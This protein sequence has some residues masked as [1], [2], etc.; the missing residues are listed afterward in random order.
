MQ[1]MDRASLEQLLS[2]GLS[3]AEI[4]RRFGLHESTVGYWVEKHGLRAAHRDKHLARGGLACEDL[5]PLVQRG[6]TIAEIAEAVGRSKATVRHWLIRHGL[7]TQGGRGRRPAKE[8]VAAKQAGLSTVVMRCRHH[9]ET[10]F[11]LTGQ[12]SYRCKRC[13]S[14]A[15]ARRRRKVKEI[16]VEEAG[17]CCC[18]CGYS[19]NMRALHFHHLEPSQ[20]RHEINAKGVAIALDKLRVE[21]RKCVLLCS[22]CHAEVED[23][24][25]LI[26]SDM[27]RSPG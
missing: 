8:A 10:E 5:E 25:A 16:L 12:G 9:G 18:I 11:W 23:G 14:A 3:L 4:G 26:P 22:N 27:S 6:A 17:G 15:V 20:K 13:R 7:K 1:C 24:T 19:R 2:R 21:A